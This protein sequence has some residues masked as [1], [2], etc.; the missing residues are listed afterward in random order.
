MNWSSS[1]LDSLFLMLRNR[2]NIK[3]LYIEKKNKKKGKSKVLIVDWFKKAVD[4]FRKRK[5]VLYHD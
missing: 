1:E 5:I 2:M 3:Y 4:R